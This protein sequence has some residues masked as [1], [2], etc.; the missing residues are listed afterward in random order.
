V[1]TETVWGSARLSTLEGG[2]LVAND[3]RSHETSLVD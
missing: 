3:E 2:T 1:I